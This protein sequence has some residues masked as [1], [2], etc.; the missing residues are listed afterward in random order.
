MAD[1]RWHTQRI[2]Q[3]HLC[4]CHRL[5]AIGHRLLV[6]LHGCASSSGRSLWSAGSGFR[7][8][9]DNETRNGI[10]SLKEASDLFK[11]FDVERKLKDRCQEM[12]RLAAEKVHGSEGFKKHRGRSCHP[13][14]HHRVGYPLKQP[15]IFESEYLTFCLDQKGMGES[16]TDLAPCLSERCLGEGS[17]KCVERQSKS[18]VGCHYMKGS[19]ESQFSDD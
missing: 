4:P 2:A 18:I 6:A 13:P 19:E 14:L 5:S 7:I 17:H 9:E 3:N 8:D 15:K 12:K 16:S 11:F 1:G 10:A